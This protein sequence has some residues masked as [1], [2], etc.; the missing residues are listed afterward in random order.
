[1]QIVHRLECEIAELE[2]KKPAPLGEKERQH[3]MRLGAD[4]EL[5]W[6]QPAAAAETRKR[7][8]RTALHE[9]VA[10]IEGAFIE[11]VLHWQGGDRTALQLKVNALAL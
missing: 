5:T 10:R 6:S 4:L 11:M 9:I 8:L 1:L 3:L 7:I 2:A